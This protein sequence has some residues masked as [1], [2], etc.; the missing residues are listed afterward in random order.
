MQHLLSSPDADVEFRI[1]DH[2]PVAMLLATLTSLQQIT[3]YIAYQQL[4]RLSAWLEMALVWLMR[5]AIVAVLL[6]LIGTG[7][8]RL[9]ARGFAPWQIVAVTLVICAFAATVMEGGGMLA[10]TETIH[11]NG[12]NF[13]FLLTWNVCY[14]ALLIV[15]VEYAARATRLAHEVQAIEMA[16]LSAESDAATAHLQLL[17]AQVEPHFLF[18]ALANVR[19]LMRVDAPSA[20]ALLG[21][22]LHYLEA[23]LPA[24]RDTTSTLGQEI[25]LVRS[26]LA[27]HQVRMGPRLVVKIDAPDSVL[28]IK[29]PPMSLM[30][31]VE[32]SLKHGLQPMV[33]GG[34]IHISAKSVPTQGQNLHTNTLI[35]TV[36]DTGRG[37]GSGLGGGTGLA[38]LRARMRSMYGATGT[39]ELAMNDPHGM[40]V[41]LSMPTQTLADH[42]TGMAQ[43]QTRTP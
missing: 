35:L 39:L 1:M 14:V 27:V 13:R 43:F 34:T 23:A 26:F 9:A 19:R 20:R 3:G 15:S 16:R 21:D 42:P 8:R 32:N 7:R 18:N 36:A 28:D 33:D 6:T 10:T 37:M 11:F 12:P 25:A 17:Q 4:D 31:L 22:L 2:L 29:I 40:V 24:L 5:L 30:T 38:N 41:T